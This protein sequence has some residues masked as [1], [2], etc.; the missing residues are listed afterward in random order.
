M[1]ISVLRDRILD[2]LADSSAPPD[3]GVAKPPSVHGDVP[4]PLRKRFAGRKTPAGVLIPLLARGTTYHVLFTRRS[5]DLRH[6]PGQVSFPGG[7]MESSDRDITDAALREAEEEV[8]LPRGHVRIAGYLESHVTITG[9]AVTPVVGLVHRGFRIRPQPSEVE[10][11][12]EVPLEFLMEVD[13]LRCSW[14][15]FEG[16]E[17]PVYECHYGGHRIWGATAA[18]LVTLRQKLNWQ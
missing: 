15:E 7:R 5:P 3:P 8:G 12:F 6:H 13:N 1:S 9:Y 11:A 10:E 4:E 17:V 16:V 18:M 14:R 2:A